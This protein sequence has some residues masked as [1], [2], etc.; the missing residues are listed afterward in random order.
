MNMQKNLWE[1]FIDFMKIM[2][3]YNKNKND[4]TF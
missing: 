2:D 4:K 3:I 1:N